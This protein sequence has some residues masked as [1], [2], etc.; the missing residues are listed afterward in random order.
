MVALAVAEP[1]A[2]AGAALDIAHVSHAF[3]IDGAA[4]P[5]LEDVNLQIEPGEFVALLGPSGCGKSTLLRLVAGLEPPRSGSLRED[6]LRIRG[7]IPRAWS[8]SRT[9]RCFRGGRCGTMSRSASK[10]RAS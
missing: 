4:L 5:V 10:R 2:R 3:D 7:H 9:P 6:D 8:C 1:S